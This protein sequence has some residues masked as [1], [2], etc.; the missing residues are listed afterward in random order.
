MKRRSRSKTDKTIAIS[1]YCLTFK[2]EGADNITPRPLPQAAGVRNWKRQVRDDAVAASGRGTEASIWINGVTQPGQSFGGPHD[3]GD[4]VSLDHK[5]SS[6]ISGLMRVG[7][8]GFLSQAGDIA[9]G[10]FIFTEQMATSG[11]MNTGRRTYF[12]VF[13]HLGY[14]RDHGFTYNTLSINNLFFEGDARLVSHT[15]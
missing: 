11:P 5:L 3:S 7:T 8:S 9:Q 4:F 6:V 14:D 15:I 1:Q 13:G 2:F 10:I 12:M